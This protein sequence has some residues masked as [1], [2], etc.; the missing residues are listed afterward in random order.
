MA[1]K[2]SNNILMVHILMVKYM[3]N[4]YHGMNGQQYKKCTY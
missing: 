4:I 1:S 2:W 3:E